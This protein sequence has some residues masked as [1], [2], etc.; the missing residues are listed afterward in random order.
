MNLI[1]NLYSCF[2]KPEK[3]VMETSSDVECPVCW[4]YQEYDSEIRTIFEDKHIDVKNHKD[5]YMKVQK[6]MVEHLK[7]VRYKKGKIKRSTSDLDKNSN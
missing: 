3:A 2:K 5:H 1:D 4:G 6:F 7:G